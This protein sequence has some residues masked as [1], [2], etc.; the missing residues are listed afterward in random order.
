MAGNVPNWVYVPIS[1]ICIAV[2]YISIAQYRKK[3]K[4]PTC[5][6]SLVGLTKIEDEGTTYRWQY[7]Y[8]VNEQKY[9]ATAS[10]GSSSKK[11]EIGKRVTVSYN[12]SNP[13]ES[14]LLSPAHKYVFLL[15]LGMGAACI[16]ELSVRL[17]FVSR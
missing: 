12:P 10:L 13:Q 7:E 9:I 8:Q 16:Y 3:N 2:A 4:W 17:G 14:D 11:I 5:S 15:P 1:A 6:G